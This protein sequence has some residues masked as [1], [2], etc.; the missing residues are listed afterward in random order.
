MKTKPVPPETTLLYAMRRCMILARQFQADSKPTAHRTSMQFDED[1]S[2][3][4]CIVRP[5]DPQQKKEA[6]KK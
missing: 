4:E 5:V 3:W 1:D 2:E 6:S